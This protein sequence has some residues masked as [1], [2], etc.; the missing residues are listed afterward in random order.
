MTS[1]RSLYFLLPGLVFSHLHADALMPPVSV[2]ASLT[3]I[4]V[5]QSGSTLSIIDEQAIEQR[6][7][8]YVYDLLR[9]V[10]GTAIGQSGGVGTLTH[11]RLRGAETNHTLVL[12]DG[13]E[14]NNVNS[15]AFNFAHLVTCGLER[16][17]VLRGPQSS[18]W[19]S[20]ALAG[21]VNVQTKKG[22]GPLS[23]ESATSAG[24][25][26]TRQNCSGL[27]AGNGSH[28]F[29]AYGAYFENNGTNISQT[30]N[31]QDGY[32][33]TSLHVNYAIAASQNLRFS[34]SGRHV[35]AAVE[36]D[37]FDPPRDADRETESIHNYF[38]LNS[39]L[40]TFNSTLNHQASISL[41]D[42]D[43]ENFTARVKT[44][45]AKQQKLK[46]AY[47]STLL[48]STDRLDSSLTLAYE[49]ERERYENIARASRFG[50]PNQRQK[51]YNN[52][53]IGEYRA[54]LFEQLFLSAS[55]RYDDNGGFKNRATQRFT[56]S[57]IPR[58]FST[59]LQ[60]A[61]GTGV[62]NPGYTERFGF[63]P[64][65]FVGNP[66]IKP[67]KSSGWEIGFSHS[68]SHHYSLGSTYFAEQLE[69]E[70]S[71]G[72]SASGLLTSVNL[73]GE[74]RRKGIELWFDAEPLENLNLKASYT[75]VDSRQPG[76]AGYTTEVRVPANTASLVANYAFLNNRANINLRINYI[77][78]KFDRD[79]SSFPF[80]RVELSDYT[81]VNIAGAY[82]INALITLEGRIE[83]LFDRGYQ[84]VFGYE[85]PGI[86]AH[87][88]LKF[89]TQ[90]NGRK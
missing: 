1:K 66:D 72:R 78:D 31:E 82:R 70:I 40:N 69:D 88:G 14:V 51:T 53:Y 4:E 85:T 38:R 15:G 89:H 36:T 3:P 57:F 24:R 2:T 6:Q 39:S 25:F 11:L 58:G 83:N 59:R 13:I 55:I 42:T 67:E 5:R 79:F 21:V 74:S 33:N 41:M 27:S 52:G 77:D 30:G 76:R 64:A 65:R 22:A 43:D 17:E 7:A 62:K 86:N 8:P 26:D 81:L 28:R 23:I 84:D 61:Y 37:P 71:S 63:F 48:H 50:D 46:F 9:D 45:A 16:I 90:L 20:D 47:Q 35:D 44:S 54:G 75:Y 12:I 19:G 56:A 80:Q 29:S 73:D 49:R 32:R 18:L 60:A 87:L 34:F 10:P 68:F